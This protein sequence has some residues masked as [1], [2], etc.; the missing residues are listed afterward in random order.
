MH[1]P[2]VSV[3]LAR[4]ERVTTLPHTGRD[5]E[6]WMW[7]ILNGGTVPSDRRVDDM[8]AVHA[9][10]LTLRAIGQNGQADV[11]LDAQMQV[12]ATEYA[13]LLGWNVDG[14]AE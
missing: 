13:R 3:S 4:P 1:A 7:S 14:K 5:V 10:A 12:I 11:P 6:A 9:H 8:R 2:E